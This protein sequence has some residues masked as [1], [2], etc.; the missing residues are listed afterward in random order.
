MAARVLILLSKRSYRA[1]DFLD[2]AAH[3]GVEVTVGTDHRPT[4]ERFAPEATLY[5][6]LADP[7]QS[8]P[9]ILELD[10]SHRLRAVIAAEDDGVVLAAQAASALGLPHN[11]PEAVATAHRKDHM[12]RALQSAGVT[13]P[14]WIVQSTDVEPARA[15]ERAAEAVGYPLVLKPVSLSASRGVIRANDAAEFRS[16]WRLI[17]AILDE[18][19][20]RRA[21]REGAG[22]ILSEAYI[23]GVEMALEGILDDGEL[24]L[25]ALLDKPDPLE[26]PFFEETLYVT[27]SRWAPEAQRAALEVTA[28]AC[29]A[30]GLQNGPIHAEIRWDGKLAWPLE[31]AP[32]SIGGLCSR[33]LRF[34]VGVSLEEL[35]LRHACRLEPLLPDGIAG[36]HGREVPLDPPDPATAPPAQKARGAAGVLM[37][38]VP[39]AGV[40]RSVEGREA[41]L[42][43]PGIEGVTILARPGDMLVPAPE[44]HRYPG[45][46]FG[47]GSD[48]AAVEAALRDAGSRIRFLLE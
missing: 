48:P 44:G 5:L 40:L 28:R 30:L 46:V 18:P 19:D 15:A 2:A 38:P 27:P 12:R 26:G 1:D 39:E 31:V 10:R 20:V 17:V 9:C 23:P 29:A 6:D 35:I 16:A 33:V 25:L 13:S 45:F 8:I 37:L 14:P 36:G 32:R 7:D 24:R 11:P 43:I 42:G 21:D 34:G 4:L 47:R 22:L 3:L 41:A